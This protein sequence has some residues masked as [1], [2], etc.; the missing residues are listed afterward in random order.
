MCFVVI[1]ALFLEKRH[2]TDA[3]MGYYSVIGNCQ[4]RQKHALLRVNMNEK[5]DPKLL[6]CL[7]LNAE[8][9]SIP[10]IKVFLESSRLPVVPVCLTAIDLAMSSGLLP[11]PNDRQPS[12][13]RRRDQER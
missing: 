11:S 12:P 3:F 7:A 10:P 8:L 6:A 1:V 9:K 5:T 2:K 4:V 13:R